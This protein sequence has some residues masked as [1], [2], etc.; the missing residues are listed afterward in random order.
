MKRLLTPLAFLLL[1]ATSMAQPTTPQEVLEGHVA[2]TGGTEAWSS[3][4]TIVASGSRALDMPM[5]KMSG[6]F[7]Q[8]QQFPGFG[9]TISVT[10]SPMGSMRQE[11]LETPDG[12]WTLVRG[13]WQDREDSDPLSLAGPKTELALLGMDSGTF[14]PLTSDELNGTPVWVISF[15]VGDTEYARHYRKSDLLLHSSVRDG[16]ST[17]YD[18]YREVEGL[19]IPHKTVAEGLARVNRNGNVEEMNITIESTVENIALN[20]PIPEDT[21]SR[22]SADVR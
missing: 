19:L 13:T 5:G 7:E 12:A 1:A 15:S 2:A 9:R 16:L 20:A 10:E 17:H 4:G 14:G 21:F 3:V 18:D 22:D 8:L 6:S 11:V